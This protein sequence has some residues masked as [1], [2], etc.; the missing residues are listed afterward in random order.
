MEIL[1]SVHSKVLP[2][3]RRGGAVPIRTPR[4]LGFPRFAKA[5]ADEAIPAVRLAA[6][7]ATLLQ[8]NGHA[9]PVPE[10]SE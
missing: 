2:F 3:A 1:E 9:A 7:P 6:V 5:F 10:A 4:F 8:D